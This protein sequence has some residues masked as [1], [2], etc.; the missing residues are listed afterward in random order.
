MIGNVNPLLTLEDVSSGFK[1]FGKI[2]TIGEQAR[3]NLASGY[4]GEQHAGHKK[5]ILRI[6]GMA[7]QA[8]KD[9]QTG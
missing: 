3:E 6:D 7:A 4:N 5:S 9:P 2:F 1:D 8:R